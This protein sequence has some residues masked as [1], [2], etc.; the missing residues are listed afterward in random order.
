[1]IRI[2]ATE[3][4][5]RKIREAQESVEIVDPLGNR[6][7]YFARAFSDEDLRLARE[8][9]ASNEQRRSTKMVVERL[10]STDGS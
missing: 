2:V 9:L 5:A 1:M 10:Q 6:L 4:Q 7:G 8:R 3:E